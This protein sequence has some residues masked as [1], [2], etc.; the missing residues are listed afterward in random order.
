MAQIGLFTRTADGFSGRL[1][2]LVLDA[3]LTLVRVET[4]DGGNAPDYRIH[5]GDSAEGPEVGAGWTRTGERAGEYI[6]VVLDDPSLAQ[7][8]R[9]TLFQSGRGGRV[10][11]LVWSRP[12][13]RQ[14]A[15]E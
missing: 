10:W 2:T 6:V 13:K 8:V 5:L 11:Q 15:R 12:Q 14:G 4:P 3:E 9:A 1:R 7:G